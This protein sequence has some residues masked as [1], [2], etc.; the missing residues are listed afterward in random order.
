M[1]I[2]SRLPKKLQKVVYDGFS[3][4]L[5]EPYRVENAKFLGF[6]YNLYT[7]KKLSSRDFG[8]SVNWSKQN[9]FIHMNKIAK[10]MLESRRGFT[11]SSLTFLINVAVPNKRGDGK[12]FPDNTTYVEKIE[13]LLQ[14]E[15]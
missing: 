14:K 4:P 1:G 3:K 9:T 2:C 5:D 7:G 12:T 15:G 13:L 11:S 10:I 8:H 6:R